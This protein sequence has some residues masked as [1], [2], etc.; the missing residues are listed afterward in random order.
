[1]TRA[2]FTPREFWILGDKAHPAGHI[3]P[4]KYKDGIRV[5]EVL[6][7]TECAPPPV[8]L[9]FARDLHESFMRVTKE[10]DEAI[11]LLERL[12][13]AHAPDD[14]DKWQRTWADVGALLAKA[15]GRAERSE[16]RNEP[17]PTG[18]ESEVSMSQ[19]KG[20]RK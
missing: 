5:R 13:E 20:G 17:R 19:R 14:H 15:K 16:T 6:P 2:K 18:R 1:M 11:A 8:G 7:A 12:S 3:V 10:R 9:E 4:D